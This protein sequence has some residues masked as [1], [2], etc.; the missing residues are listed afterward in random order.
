MDGIL[1][2]QMDLAAHSKHHIQ[3]H[4]IQ[5]VI[6]MSMVISSPSLSRSATCEVPP[7][8]VLPHFHLTFSWTI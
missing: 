3:Y 8:V 4:M 7:S 5:I 2:D 6:K 1:S